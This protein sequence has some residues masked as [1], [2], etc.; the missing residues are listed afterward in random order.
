[1]MRILWMC[2]VPLPI[3]SKDMGKPIIFGGGWMVGLC[4][5][6]IQAGNKLGI[7]FPVDS[8]ESAKQG[9]VDDISYFSIPCDKFSTKTDIQTVATIEHAIK[10]FNPDVV[11]IWGTE[12]THS[13]MTYY[14]C[15]N[16]DMASNTVVSIQGLVSVIADHYFAGMP[17]RAINFRS[18][19]DIIR[20]NS[21]KKE[22]NSFVYRGTSEKELLGKISYVIGRTDWDKACVHALAPNAKY[23]FCNETMRSSFY[24][25]RWN[26]DNCERYS[27]FVSQCQ[28]PIKGFHMLLKAA[29]L[30]KKRYP[31]MKIY[32][33]GKSRK[34]KNLK[35]LLSF[36]SYDFYLFW[37]LKS[38][39]LMSNVY[40][41]GSL[42]EE[43]MC[44][45]FLRAHVFVS[46]SSIENSPNSVGEAMLLGVPTIASDV[47]GVKNMI[48]HGSDGLL[49]P[50]DDI[51]T[52]ADYVCRVFEDD[53]YALELS[54]S[55]RKK[56]AFTHS[57]EYNCCQM[58]EIYNF[59][60]CNK[61][62]DD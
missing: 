8:K 5:D 7:C 54:N 32:V 12:Y 10:K 37:L 15:E 3:I 25:S 59:I 36:S 44:R 35:E 16:L 43:E 21:I 13:L 14:A 56:A 34:G 39:D 18:L 40:F 9:I 33:T 17:W 38:L 30:I 52:L 48:T 61:R 51:Y 31:N 23:L 49:Y 1:M 27:I 57:R 28:Y 46:P 47:G 62:K 50:F 24:S 60:S 19:K 26:I 42:Q 29:A 53:K 20:N 6:L 4:E 11:H 58:M 2:N 45:Q 41:L 55:A 22:R